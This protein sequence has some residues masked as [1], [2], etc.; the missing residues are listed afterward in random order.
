MGRRSVR[1]L[2]LTLLAAAVPVDS[3]RPAG[4]EPAFDPK[5]FQAMKYRLVGPYRGGRA[6]AVTGVP[7]Q[8]DTFYM[9]STGG[10]VWKTRDGGGSWIN[11]SD[12]YFASGSVG[13]VA[14]AQSDPNV[15]YAGTGSACVRGNISPGDGVYKSTDAGETWMHIGLDEAGQIGRIRVHPQD[16][17]LVYVAALG[18]IFGP[19]DERGVFR[20]SDGGKTWEHVL[21]VSKHAG[22]VD[23]SMDP[24][25]PRILYATIW[26]V[27]RKPWTLTSGGE[28]NGLWKS[29]DGGDTWEKLT[30]GLPE[31]STGRIG[32]SASGAKSG[33]V[34]A[35][36]EA[37]D[38]GLFRSEDHGK[39]FRLINPDRNFRQRA[40]YYTHV[41]ADP[42]DPETVYIM[43]V[44]FWRSHNA[45]KDFDFIRVPHG[46]NHDMWINPDDNQILIEANDGG[47]NV[48]Y[49]GGKSWSTQTNQPTA[50]FYRVTVDEQF[51]YRL[52]GG[53]QD[54]ST[55]SIPSRTTSSA[56]TRQHWYAVAGCE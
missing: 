51:P 35:L 27:E 19:N 26:Q 29:S 14:V 15:V 8:R 38:G 46:D 23:L 24:N 1:C 33:R 47:A 54:N 43:N 44:G 3:V 36:V 5:L 30:E 2:L 16:H 48:S 20:S 21:K 45:G 10:G 11:V 39:T 13:A 32:V 55:V 17:E 56:I 9:G 52:Y 34:Y 4:D 37:D 18:H 28:D 7:G 41:Y 40:W 42:V 50:E 49:N 53:Q 31:G 12:E 22:A 25:N 6:T